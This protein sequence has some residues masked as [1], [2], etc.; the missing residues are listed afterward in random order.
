MQ[1]HVQAFVE[2]LRFMAEGMLGIFAVMA[3]IIAVIYGLNRLTARG[4]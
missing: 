4:E 1:I 2:S 3:V